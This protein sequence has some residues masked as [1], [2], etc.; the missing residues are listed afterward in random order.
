MGDFVF[1]IDVE[2][3]AGSAADRSMICGIFY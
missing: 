1:V 3:M 2:G